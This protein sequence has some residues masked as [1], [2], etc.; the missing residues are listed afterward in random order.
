MV[1]NDLVQRRLKLNATLTECGGDT[2]HPRYMRAKASLTK[3]VKEYTSGVESYLLKE[4]RK[5]QHKKPETTEDFL[6]LMLKEQ[7]KR[8]EIEL[9]MYDLKRA[10]VF[11]LVL[12]HPSAGRSRLT[13]K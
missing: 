5:G 10:E 7:E 11:P 2:E 8:R 9:K 4:K 13:R 3:R 12:S 6:A 1:V